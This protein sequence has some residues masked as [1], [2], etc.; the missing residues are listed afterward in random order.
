MILA[1]V[2]HLTKHKIDRHRVWNDG[3]SFRTRC[4]RCGSE[5]V[6]SPQSWR[7]FDPKNDDNPLRAEHP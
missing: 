7:R 6:R 1:L 5:L 2:C 4:R 3:I